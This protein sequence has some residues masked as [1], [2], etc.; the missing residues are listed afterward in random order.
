MAPRVPQP[1]GLRGNVY[2]KDHWALNRSQFAS[3]MIGK[4]LAECPA[5]K[6]DVELANK[7]L[8]LNNMLQM[9]F[10]TESKQ[11]LCVAHMTFSAWEI[12]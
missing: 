11:V 12:R 9:S 2:P 6:L 1:H 4:I 10:S 5:D 3:R 7:L 8:F